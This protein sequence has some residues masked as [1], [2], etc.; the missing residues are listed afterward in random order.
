[1][2]LSRR[3]REGIAAGQIALVFRR[4]RRPSV[5]SGG[6]LVTAIGLLAIEAVDAIA[7]GEIG[8]A[9]A[10]AAGYG[11]RAALLAE[12][13]GRE[14][15]LYRIRLRLSGA[16]PRIALRENA[17]L[18][19]DDVAELLQRLKRLDA[20]EPWTSATLELIAA[21]PGR[22]AP[23]L[24]AALGRETAAFKQ[25]VRKLKAL[26]LTESREIGYQLSPR[27]QAFLARLA[28]D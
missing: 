19:D 27:G 26:G 9:A 3:E 28:R 12:L 15:Q 4:W 25:A 6:T 7:D 20:R 24:A 22:R 10:Q 5:R 18:S 11:S 16:D 17:L 13:A 1:M 14:G 2:L 23:E 8:D 21:R